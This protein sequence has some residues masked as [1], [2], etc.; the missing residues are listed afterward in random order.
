[1][2]VTR[3]APLARFLPPTMMAPIAPK[4]VVGSLVKRISW[5]EMQR[6]REKGLCFNCNDR[7]TPGHKCKTPQLFLIEG[8]EDEEKEGDFKNKA[9]TFGPIIK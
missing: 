6:M 7:F 8:G 1:M 2:E 5:E 3:A 4:Q 9:P